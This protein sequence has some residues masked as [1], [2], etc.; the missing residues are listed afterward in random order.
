MKTM[1]KYYPNTDGIFHQRLRSAEDLICNYRG[2]PVTVIAERYSEPH[3]ESVR[4]TMIRPDGTREVIGFSSG[5]P[6][7]VAAHVSTSGATFR[8]S[9]A[10]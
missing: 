5:T 10:R 9:E 2:T 8:L 1:S 4:V 6:E 3:G 7:S